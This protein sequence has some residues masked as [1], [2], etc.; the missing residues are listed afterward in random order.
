[1]AGMEAKGVEVKIRCT[2]EQKRLNECEMLLVEHNFS[3]STRKVIFRI[4]RNLF[5]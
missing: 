1:M 3:T 5:F 4:L 2:G